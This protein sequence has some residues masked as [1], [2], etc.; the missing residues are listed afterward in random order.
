M[1][2]NQRTQL[3]TTF[4]NAWGKQKKQQPL[5][6][7]EQSIVTLI[8]EHPEYIAGIENMDAALETDYALDDNPFL[9][10]SLHLSLQDQIQTNRP[11]GIQA[12]YHNLLK[13]YQD[14]HET[15][16]RMMDVL[17][18]LLLDAQKTNKMPDESS[19]LKSLCEL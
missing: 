4:L 7:L 10:L 19:Y 6:A 18:H 3:R 12:I 2:N 16:H 15:Q 1:S 13:K 17:A 9:H 11:A 8:A 14:P 5:S